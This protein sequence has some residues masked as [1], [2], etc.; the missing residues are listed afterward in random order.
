MKLSHLPPTRLRQ[1]T[2][3]LSRKDRGTTVSIRTSDLLQF[4]MTTSTSNSVLAPLLNYY[5]SLPSPGLSV[6]P[7]LAHVIHNLILI[8]VSNTLR[9]VWFPGRSKQGTP[10]ATGSP[11]VEPGEPGSPSR[12]ASTSKPGAL[13]RALSLLSGGRRSLTRDR[14][15]RAA[16]P[17]DVGPNP[18]RRAADLLDRFLA[19]LLPGACDPDDAEAR[20]RVHRLADGTLDDAL[21]PVLVLLTRLATADAASRRTLYNR[22]FPAELDRSS[23]LEKRADTLGRCLRLLSAVYHPRSRDAAGEL[24]YALCSSDGAPRLPHFRGYPMGADAA[25]AAGILVG[26]VGYGNVAGLLYNKGVMAAPPR[27][28]GTP[29]STPSGQA[30]NPITGTTYAPP[31]SGPEMTDEEKEEEAE[32]LFVLFDRLEKNGAIQPSQNPVRKAMQEAQKRK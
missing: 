14:T 11:T 25:V 29:T 8:P 17:V 3:K 23:P 4:G 2:W 20:D 21:S 6:G 31:S 1:V 22:Y 5:F 15:P 26:Q 32:K 10:S 30:I 16:S 13:D 27:A 18:A 9:P 7:P 19:E 24:L 12:E 28:E